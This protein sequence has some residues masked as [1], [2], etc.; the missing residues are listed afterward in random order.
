VGPHAE[1]R[2][3]EIRPRWLSSI[4]PAPNR[5]LVILT[6]KGDMNNFALLIPELRV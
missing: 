6:P 1:L 3:A 4:D 5:M 2:T